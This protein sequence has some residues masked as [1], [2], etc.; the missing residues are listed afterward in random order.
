MQSKD[1]NFEQ[2]TP[3]NFR[4]GDVLEGS[5]GNQ[6]VVRDAFGQPDNDE[7]YAVIDQLPDDEKVKSDF[8]DGRVQL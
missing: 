3:S 6:Y 1:V 4:C 8:L 2:I 5:D 7:Q